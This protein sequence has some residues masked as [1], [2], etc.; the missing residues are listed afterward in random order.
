M[1]GGNWTSQN[2][3]RPGAYIQFNSESKPFGTIGERGVVTMGAQLS[4]GPSKQ[5]V[6]I[7]SGD[8]VR[9][10]LGYD[11]TDPKVLLVR[12]ALKRA[13]TL[14]LYR[15][16]TGTQASAIHEGLTITA[17]H[18]GVRGND[19]SIVVQ[20]HMD[21]PEKFDVK[22][23]LD[24][25]E[26]DVQVVADIDDLQSNLWVDFSGSGPLASTA[27]V[28]LE[29]GSDGSVTN[30]DHVDF[31]AAAQLLDFQTIA[32]T[33]DDV[34]LKSLY[35]AFVKRLREDEGKKVQAV[36]PE[37]PAAD[38][39]GVISV[40]NGVIL[41]DGTILT[42]AQA[43]AWTAGATAGAQV[44]ESLTYTAYED[45]V[46]VS[47]RYT[48]SQIEAAL[49]NGEF[50]FSPSNGRAIV[51][52]DINTLTSFTPSK[53]KQ[54]GKN[55]VVR[56]LDGLANDY[57]RIFESFYIGK[58]DNNPDGRNLFKSE[59]MNQAVAYEEINAIQHFDPQNDIE[60][61]AGADSDAVIVNQW[62]QPVD[63]IEKIYMTVTVR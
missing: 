41:S 55:R 39:E 1:A 7:H 63:A 18:G 42:A 19:I 27:G 6:E 56:V 50:V 13:G 26:V 37:Y 54:F 32:L 40:K 53:D 46:D 9:D 61:L 22:T 62:V 25:Q 17:K 34:S 5:M 35:T 58:V 16:N 23:L 24:G 21:E 31:L 28:K 60:V 36:I 45:A 44:N 49:R 3:V 4:W 48:N 59:C 47:P 52:Q 57:K 2:K 38:D 20:E 8:P 30:Q 43:C 14:L 12:E 29:G 33:T 15:L 51:E 10:V 11:I